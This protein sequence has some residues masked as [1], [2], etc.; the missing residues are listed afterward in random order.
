[1]NSVLRDPLIIVLLGNLRKPENLV[2]P[3][4]EKLIG[5]GLG[6]KVQACPW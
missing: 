3:Y 1:M 5:L 6:L 4:I 2:A